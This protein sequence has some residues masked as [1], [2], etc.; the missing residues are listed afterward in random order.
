MLTDM[1]A[2]TSMKVAGTAFWLGYTVLLARLLPAADYGLVMYAI[3]V[4]SI[5]GPLTCLGLNSAMLRFGSIYWQQGRPDA[6]LALLSAARRTIAAAALAGA[7]AVAVVF[8]AALGIGAG[9]IDGDGIAWTAV[10]VVA[11]GLPLYG[12]MEIHRETLRAL[13]RVVAGFL[14]FNVLR[15]LVP[16]V[17]AAVLAAAGW[18]TVETALAGFVGGLALIA[19][20]DGR[21]IAA[22]T[23]GAGAGRDFADRPA[24]LRV[25]RPMVLAEALVHWLAR[26][27]V[28]LVGALLDLRA[29]AIYLT[30]QRLAVLVSFVV[31]AVRLT[32]EPMVARRHAERDRAGMQELMARGSLASVATGLPIALAIA[33]GGWLLLGLYGAEFR[34]GWAVL[35]ILVLGQVTTVLAGPV[36]AVLR[37][38]GLE[39]PLTAVLAAGAVALA[40]AVPAGIALAGV[41]GAA[42]GAALVTAA[43]NLAY[44]VI[45]RRRL[46]LRIGPGSGMLAPALLRTMLAEAV[47]R[48]RSA[49]R[50]VGR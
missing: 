24:W 13:D 22:L 17:A 3:T 2:V 46:G 11:A 12:A 42:A 36:A 10:V 15:A 8:Q 47:R 5:A 33:A 43:S 30:A 18:L 41:E 39:R 32:L 35:A 38:T 9:G 49:P 25:A 7:V 37:M 19:A 16:G 14:G 1:V 31:D 26:G 4:L 21:R 29:A 45:A 20:I 44:L 27:D 34:D 6:L 23:R 50:G 28:L 48:L 40:A